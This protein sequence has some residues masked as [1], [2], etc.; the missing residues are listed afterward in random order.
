MNK[1]AMYPIGMLRNLDIFTPFFEKYLPEGGNGHA[2]FLSDLITDEN[3]EAVLADLQ[4]IFAQYTS[5]TMAEVREFG[6]EID[7]GAPRYLWGS[8]EMN[9][10]AVHLVEE[11]Y[12]ITEN[13]GHVICYGPSNITFWYSLERDMLPY[14][15]Q[16]H[17][18]G[19]CMDEDL[20]R[21][22]PR[23]LYPYHPK[24]VIVQT[25]SNDIANGV[26]LETI[27]ENKKKMYGLFREELPDTH[28]IVCS[29]LPLPGRQQFWEATVETNALLKGMC[30]ETENLHFLDASDAMMGDTG[31]EKFRAYDGRYFRPELYRIDKIHLNKRGH[32]VWTRLM[33][34]KLREIGIPA[35]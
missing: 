35:E 16:N 20:I 26:P 34:D 5:L 28:F 23:L 27:L 1:L 21:Y 17:G 3:R 9:E 25:G 2:A 4:D 10:T 12:P 15:V 6:V 29:G 14:R 18:L 33:L 30:E 24:A 13:Q 31:D 22:A 7:P 19:G 11:R 8:P 32:D